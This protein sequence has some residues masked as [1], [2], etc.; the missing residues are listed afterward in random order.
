M[1]ESCSISCVGL[2]VLERLLIKNFQKHAR[3]ELDLDPHVTVLAGK[4]DAG[5]SSIIRALRW[6]ATNKPGGTSFIRREGE[7]QAAAER[8]AVARLSVD[9]HVI[10]RIRGPR[11]NLFL[12]DGQPLAAF[13]AGVPDPVAQLL[14]IGQISLQLQH[15]PPYLFSLSPG[16]AAA[17]LDEV[18]NLDAIDQVMARLASGLRA[19]KAAAEAAQDRLREAKARRNELAWVPAADAS[20]CEAKDSY[21]LYIAVQK[22]R[23]RLADLL[24]GV[25]EAVAARDLAATGLPVLARAVAAGAKELEVRGQRAK[26]SRLLEELDCT[27]LQVGKLLTQLGEVQA[28][29]RKQ[30]RCPLCGN[31]FSKKHQNSACNL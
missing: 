4:S 25:R 15:D 24:A 11:R 6:L 17:A 9:G 19:A 14:N 5:K 31:L 28:R 13:G 27:K 29:L 12:L 26:L 20:L 8:T 3:L 30:K 2:V 21:N 10:K 22:K 23:A 18:V 7:D 1:K 16:Q